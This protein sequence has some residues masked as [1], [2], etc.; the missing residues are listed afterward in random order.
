MAY[1]SDRGHGVFGSAKSRIERFM[2]ILMTDYVIISDDPGSK[3]IRK[4]G[5]IVNTGFLHDSQN[6]LLYG[7]LGYI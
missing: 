6:S 5:F 7:R 1:F 3:Y 4:L 2:V